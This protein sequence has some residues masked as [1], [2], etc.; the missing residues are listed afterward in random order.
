M[1]RRTL[2]AV[3]LLAVFLMVFI[4]PVLTYASPFAYFTELNNDNIQ[5]MGG[6][7][8]Y[9]QGALIPVSSGCQPGG[10]TVHPATSRAYV[11]CFTGG[12]GSGTV[13]VINTLTNAVDG[14]PI[15]V[16]TGPN[17]IA[18]TADG[19]NIY[20]AN[21]FSN[22]VS[23]FNTQ[24]RVEAQNSPITVGTHPT[25]VAIGTNSQGTFAYITNY[26]NGG[27]GTVS[28]INTLNNQEVSS[29]SPITVGRGP[30]GIALNAAGT[31]AYVANSLDSTVS[32]I[33]TETASVIKTIT[34]APPTSG[35][36]T[37][38]GI[39]VGPDGTV[40]VT[41]Y[42]AG[43]VS[44]LDAA[45]N[46]AET[47]IDVGSASGPIGIDV[48][49]AGTLVYVGNRRGFT[50]SVIDAV[51]KTQVTD[52]P[53][54]VG[55]AP[56]SF[57]KFIQSTLPTLTTTSPLSSITSNAAT[58]NG[59]ITDDGGAP[60]SARGVC[61]AT[62]ANPVSGGTGVTCLPATP[63][64]GAGTFS[65]SITGLTSGQTYHAQAYATNVAGTSY[66]GDV[67]FA[68]L[69]VAPSVTTSPATAI[70]STAA[71][72]NG[73][74]TSTGGDQIS[75]E[76]VC[77]A[78]T[79]NPVSGGT[80]VT[81]LPATPSG[82][83]GTFSVSITGLTSGQTY[84]AQAYATN[85][86]GTSYGGDVQFETEDVAP[87]VTTSPATAITSAAATGN[88]NITSTGGDQ[89]SA[90]GVC[91]A[92]TAN[93]VSGGTGV[94]CLPATPSGGT[95]TFSVSITGLTSGQ[96]Y[97][98]QA[99]AANG[100]GTSYGGDAQFTTLAVA[101]SVT[102]SPATAITSAAATGNGNITSTG[103]AA[104]S[105]EGVCY[106]TTANPVSGGT[107][108]T[109]L[110]ATPSGGTGT[111]SVSI[112]GLTSGQTYHMQAFATNTAGTSYGGD[113][114]FTTLAVPTVSTSPATAIT[115]AAATGN[116]NITSTGGAAISA[117]GV[118]Y[119]TTANPVSGGTGVTCLP[120]TPSGGTGT[121]SVS[122][123][124]LT[125]GQTYHMQAFA[126][127]TAGTSYGGDAQFTTLAVAPSVTTSP[128]TAITS[129]AATGNGNITSTGGAAISAEGVCYAT[130]ANPVSGGTGVTCLPATPSGG[131]GT[132][133]VSITGLTSGQTY[134]MQA[135]ATNTAGTSYGGDA[136]FTT[137]AVP[138]V[139]TSPATAIT[140]AAA[141]GNG[142]ITSTGGAAI[143]AEGVCYATTANPVS[144][145]TGVTCLPAT[146]SGGTGT[147]SVSITGLTSGQT[148]HMQA[149][150]TN[151][152][153]TSYG[154]D[155]AFTTLAVPTVSTSPATAITSTTATGN[156]NITSTGGAAISAEG[157]C[158]A[159]TA[160]PVS[161]GTGVTCLPAT[162]SGGTGTFSVSITGL[163]PGPNLSYQ[164]FATNTVG[165]TY[166]GD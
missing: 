1:I 155:V 115:S 89:I 146:P 90:E 20:V 109:C 60:V 157:V 72:G 137:L 161:G 59:N 30:F 7:T 118:C 24:T 101:P 138:T 134:H 40:Y 145:G 80:G 83:T 50:M 126:T 98:M 156:G 158:Y 8:P 75:A 87:S 46:Y 95:G 144:G 6:S 102:T 120:A 19:S 67:Q 141:T 124:G 113:A 13:S 68:T 25:G 163:T 31:L 164:A 10:I 15:T 131:T 38:E 58:A 108:V 54:S 42:D 147:F 149:F 140:S 166:G 47:T 88:G 57:G 104:I 23:V 22:T 2:F 41:N 119:A 36:D 129:A 77:Y 96:T 116:G 110:P 66:G 63:S 91:Y 78:T 117:E 44:V 74:I 62:T 73:N 51:S 71:T 17:G 99:Y 153:G 55:A 121:F 97:H 76:G 34:L 125:S 82:G 16:G 122:I 111:F 32:V 103:G 21:Y 151:T 112:T 132:F 84:H 114:Q 14:L 29:G 92:T 86:A 136:Q 5:V 160:N 35:V 12:V 4:S 94:T 70:T 143:S 130:T 37:P 159:T 85:T 18:V 150:A 152:V 61:Y 165:R 3:W 56:W 79:A 123:T 139:S 100:E 106:A 154:G 65:V 148:Y 45:N 64:G 33:D 135:F 81:C 27:A 28:V 53:F 105:A 127:N 11:S 26:G 93:P 49:A 43:T 128:A 142:N 48:N 107:G 133:S 9:S 52:S 39:A 69:A 162:P